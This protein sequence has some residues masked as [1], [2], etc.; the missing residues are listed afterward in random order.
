MAD[1]RIIASRKLEA[2]KRLF[3]AAAE[4]SARLGVQLR[5]PT[6]PANRYPALYVAEQM[7][8]V[9][10]FVEAIARRESANQPNRKERVI[11]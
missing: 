2:E 9:A 8:N 11:A 1:P 4:V 10:D 6:V 3:K 7:E 5:T